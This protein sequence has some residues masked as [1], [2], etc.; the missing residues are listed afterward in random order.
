MDLERQRD[1]GPA[2]G[3]GRNAHSIGCVSVECRKGA[4]CGWCERR[5]DAVISECARSG[6]A[7]VLA[8][9][10]SLA[11]GRGIF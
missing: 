11:V 7:R 10:R 4:A 8:R 6:Q 2:D 1:R 9:Y 5:M 3:G